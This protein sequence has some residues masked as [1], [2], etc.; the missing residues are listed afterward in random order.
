MGSGCSTCLRGGRVGGGSKTITLL[1][2]GLD[3]AGKTCTA[4]TIVG[5]VSSFN[6]LGVLISILAFKT[7]HLTILSKLL[8]ILQSLESVAPTVGFSRVEHK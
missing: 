7:Y 6:T 8:A 2:V 5:Q 4:K 3:N 1:M